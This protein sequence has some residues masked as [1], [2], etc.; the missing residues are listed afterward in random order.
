MDYKKLVQQE[1][2]NWIG[3]KFHHQGRLKKRN[4]AHLGGVDCIGLIV[5]VARKLNL[6]SH[7]FDKD[8]NFMPLY[9]F[10]QIDY[11]REPQGQK[12]KAA[13]DEFLLP[14]TQENLEAGDVVLFTLAKYPQHVGIVGDHPQ[15]GLGIIH[16][17]QASKAVCWHALN[18][19]WLG[20][21]TGFYQFRKEAF[22]G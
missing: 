20:R 19:K 10:D 9:Q 22:Q 2:M 7:K 12:L 16:A 18:D 13:L 4:N 11:A 8:G 14:T 3:T 17:L 15:G 6:K 5:G 1:A 21:S